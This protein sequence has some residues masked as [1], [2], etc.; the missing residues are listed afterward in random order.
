MGPHAHGV[1]GEI[2]SDG[3]ATAALTPKELRARMKTMM[4]AFPK[5]PDKMLDAVALGHVQLH[6]SM[7]AGLLLTA[8]GVALSLA[9]LPV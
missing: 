7:A 5:T 1:P 8:L 2:A 6:P 3:S 9:L 4:M